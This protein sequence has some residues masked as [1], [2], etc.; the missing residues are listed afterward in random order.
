MARTLGWYL[1]ALMAVGIAGYALVNLGVADVRNPFV[2][3]LFA[4][5]PLAV[6][7]HL[8]GGA[9]AL[10]AGALQFHRG[11]RT[12]HP[13]IHR[14]IGQAYV[15]AVL[16]SGLAGLWMAVHSE[17]GPAANWGFGLLAVCWLWSTVQAWRMARARQFDAHQRWMIRSYALTLA[18]VTLRLYIPLFLIAGVSF[19]LAYLAIAWLCWV[20]NLVIAEWMVIRR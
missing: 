18:A 1:M 2:Q 15:V 12:R 7:L 4:R 16:A 17:A 20:P 9:L 6:A 11:L 8:A 19:P 3:G 5:L 14:R 13:R 10:V